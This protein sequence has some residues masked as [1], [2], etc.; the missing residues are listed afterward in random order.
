MEKEEEETDVWQ[1]IAD[2]ID[3]WSG[4]LL[5]GKISHEKSENFQCDI[6]ASLYRQQLDGVFINKRY[7]RTAIYC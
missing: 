2:A 1:D 3:N 4:R 5:D 7:Y 6:E